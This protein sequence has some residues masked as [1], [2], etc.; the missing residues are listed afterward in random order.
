MHCCDGLT[1]GAPSTGPVHPPVYIWPGD[2]H[3]A[4]HSCVH[5]SDCHASQA[6]HSVVAAV[7]AQL[8]KTVDL[9]AGCRTSVRRVPG[10]RV[11]VH[12]Q[13]WTG[14]ALLVTLVDEPRAGA[15]GYDRTPP[16]DIE[17]EQSVLGGMLLSKDAIADVVEVLRPAATSTGRRTSSST[18]R[19]WTCTAAA[20]R[21]TRSPSSAELTRT[22]QLSPG[23]RRA[24]PAHPDLRRCRRRPTPATT[25]RSSPSGRSCAGWSRPAPGSCRWATARRAA[26]DVAARRRRGRPGAGRDL[27]RHRA[28]HQ[29]GLRPHRGAAAA[30]AGRDRGDLRPHGGIGTGIP[31]GLRRAGRDHQRPAPRADDHRRRPARRSGK[32]TLGLGHCP[33]GGGEAPQADGDLLPGDGQAWRS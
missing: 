9:R 30:D 13:R 28:A 12:K 22:G 16:Q 15:A 17:A 4:V 20:S 24:V 33:V 32:S 18:T 29:R 6:V 14:R 10:I 2:S 1:A 7:A 31:T 23:R 25:P 19:S 21:P 5:S 27:R 26:G 8:P 11:C 3:S